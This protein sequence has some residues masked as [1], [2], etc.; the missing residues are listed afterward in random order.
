MAAG[1]VFF[2]WYISVNTSNRFVYMVGDLT[3]RLTEPA[4]RP[5]RKF[6]PS[7][8]NIDISPVVLIIGLLDIL[9]SVQTAIIDPAWRQVSTEGYVFAAFSFW[10]FCFSI[11]RYSQALER[12]LHTGHK[13]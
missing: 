6:L 10:V 3:Y 8:G 4:L 5:I 2:G 7:L 9:A 1:V 12:K 11:S 13:R